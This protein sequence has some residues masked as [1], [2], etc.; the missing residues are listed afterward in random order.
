MYNNTSEKYELSFVNGGGEHGFLGK[1]NSTAMSLGI[2]VTGYTIPEFYK[3]EKHVG[4]NKAGRL[5][6]VDTLE[7][8][9]LKMVE[10][11]DNII[12]AP[13]GWG[14]LEEF[15]SEIIRH[16]VAGSFNG[17][18]DKPMI[19]MHILNVDGYYDWVDGFF[20]GMESKGMTRFDIKELVTIHAGVGECLTAIVPEDD[21]GVLDLLICS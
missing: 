14:T 20:K 18:G 1:F 7:E 2:D 16:E 4:L 12:M 17:N 6:M 10:G 13:G 9:E 11:V 3:L 8:R 15:V 19:P 21:R 5:I